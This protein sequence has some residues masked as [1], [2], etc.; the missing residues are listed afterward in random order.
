MT[1]LAALFPWLITRL[2]HHRGIIG[3][4]P[5]RGIG[6]LYFFDTL[7]SGIFGG[8]LIISTALMI[9]DS[10]PLEPTA[11]ATFVTGIL[12]SVQNVLWVET[13]EQTSASQPLV[14]LCLVSAGFTI[15]IY[16]N[17]MRTIVFVKRVVLLLL[18]VSL[19]A[20]STTYGLLKQKTI[21]RHPV[22]DLVYKSR[23]EADRW[24]RHATVSTTLK[25][26]VA[27]YKDRHHGRDPPQHFDKWFEFARQRKSVVID[28]FDQ[29]EKDVFPFW[30]MKQ[31]KIR[32]GLE[33]L[34]SQ[35]DIGIIEIAGGK[36]THNEPSDPSQKMILDDTVS[37]INTFAEHLP[38]MSIAINLEERPR[39]LVPWD[40]V[41]RY[42]MAGSK[43]GFQLLSGRLHRREILESADAVKLN[44]KAVDLPYVSAQKFRQL[45]ALAC[46]PGSPSRGGV[47][48]D[49]R[50]FCSSCTLPHSK[51]QFL[52]DWE[53]S[54]DPC[55]Q[56]DI[57]N[58]HDFHTTPHRF[59]LYQDLLPLFSRSKTAS[60]NDILLPL[61][62]PD[63]S[64]EDDGKALGI[65]SETVFWQGDSNV[66]ALTHQSLHGSHRHRLVH[67]GN[68]ASAGDE[69]P[70]LL[71]IGS[72]KD[73]RFRYEHTRIRDANSVMPFQFSLTRSAENCDDANCQLLQ[74]EFGFEPPSRALD[75]RY[76]ML[77]DTAD[78]P[79]PDLV[80]TLRSN[81]VPLLSTIFQEWYTERLM[82]WVHFIPIDFRFHGLHS[83]MAYFIGLKGRGSLNGREQLTEGRLEDAFWIA[84][85][86][87]KWADKA[88]RRED[89]ETYLFRQ[90]LEWGRVIQ[91]DRD[92]LGFVLKD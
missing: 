1:S 92:E 66:E 43:P 87:R 5:F 86:G 45:Q 89:M 8:A 29:I 48:W 61:M 7:S 52:Q 54:L 3:H 10:S 55:H 35:P 36:A 47:H 14:V 11:I 26:A 12:A 82:P 74:Q 46:P 53:M 22:D 71:G 30:G 68:N 67:L 38:S 42:R 40:D 28:R 6:S 69:V 76:I 56:P 85:Q 24:L 2:F 39:V 32:D 34:K 91:D 72:G 75:N 33:F 4:Q 25:L 44:P 51:E 57:F 83:T 60:F 90:L 15:F 21:T 13:Y 62:R 58:L 49:V 88:M 37:M 20:A 9:C 27:E 73:S 77:L 16:A 81:S 79:P 18:L 59:E 84:E 50:G 78:G 70:V 17:N 41:H 80:R 23:I 31:Q 65:K 64:L 63:A 19:I